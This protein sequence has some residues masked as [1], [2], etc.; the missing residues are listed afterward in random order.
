[1]TAKYRKKTIK[2]SR[3]FICDI[4]ILDMINDNANNE[5]D[6]SWVR[7]LARTCACCSRMPSCSVSSKLLPAY[8]TKQNL[9]KVHK[10]QGSKF[11]TR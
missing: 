9:I 4:Q 3:K 2:Q 6:L 11:C 8:E 10:K 7:S 5:L 1:M